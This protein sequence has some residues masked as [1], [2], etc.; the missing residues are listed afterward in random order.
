[1]QWQVVLQQN[2]LGCWVGNQVGQLK[3]SDIGILGT[4]LYVSTGNNPLEQRRLD[5]L[6]PC[7]HKF[8]ESYLQLSV[9]LAPSCFGHYIAPSGY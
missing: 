7:F 2:V 8:A 5:R 3:A 9:I 1:M 6:I 4:Y